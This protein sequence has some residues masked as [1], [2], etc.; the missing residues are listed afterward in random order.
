MHGKLCSKRA[1]Y[2]VSIRKI[3][4]VDNHQSTRT[5]A[6]ADAPA[7]VSWAIDRIATLGLVHRR[8]L[9]PL[10]SFPSPSMQCGE[11]EESSPFSLLP[12][13]ALKHA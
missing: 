10:P 3:R 8:R 4:K 9:E 2:F 5:E 6:K 7:F 1:T 12:S 11:D 13:S